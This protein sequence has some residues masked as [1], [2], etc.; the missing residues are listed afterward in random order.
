MPVATTLADKHE[1]IDIIDLNPCVGEYAHCRGPLETFDIF[2]VQAQGWF[3]YHAQRSAVSKRW[4]SQCECCHAHLRFAHIT[5]DESGE[6]HCYGHTCLNI[7]GFGEEGARRL[8]YSAR[9]EQKKDSG[10]CATFNVPQK[11]WDLPR[12]QRPTSARV[13]K[14]KSFSRRAGVVWKLSI[15]GQSFEECLENCMDLSKLLGIKL[16]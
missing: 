16:S 15:W 3:R 5:Q 4:N 12:D 14:G 2:G 13:W 9:I 8:E 11:F 7:Q 10:F 1:L 6:Y